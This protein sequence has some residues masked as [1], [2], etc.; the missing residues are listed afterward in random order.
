MTRLT[1]LAHLLRRRLFWHRRL[2]AALAAALCVSCCLRALAPAPARTVPVVVAAHQ[3]P[4]GTLLTAADLTVRQVPADVAPDRAVAD[5]AALSGRLLA[6]PLPTGSVLTE[7]SVVSP[8]L[9]SAAPGKVLSP[10][11]IPDADLVA[12]LR[13][14]DRVDVVAPASA[15]GPT[16]AAGARVVARDARVVAIPAPVPTSSSGLPGPSQSRGS[17]VVL[18]VSASEATAVLG[19]AAE[20]RASILIR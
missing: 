3:L 1:S 2:L 15:A 20:G 17:L 16:G 5:P 8:A 12:L 18:E 13:V 9:A 6:A 14:G 11:R 19:L 7:L 10:V 4:G